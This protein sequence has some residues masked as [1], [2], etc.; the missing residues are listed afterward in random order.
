MNQKTCCLIFILGLVL[1]ACSKSEGPSSSS[2]LAPDDVAGREFRL[3]SNPPRWSV[4]MIPGEEPTESALQVNSSSYMI[5]SPAVYY[6]KTGANTASLSCNFG[7]HTVIGGNILNSYHE[8]EL[9]LVFTTPNQGHYTGIYRNQPEG[10][11]V[12]ETSGYFAFDTEEDPD[13]DPDDD[14][15]ETDYSRL[16]GSWS[17]TANGITK[18]LTMRADKSYLIV[19]SGKGMYGTESGKYAVDQKNA[20]IYLKADGNGTATRYKIILLDPDELE[21]KQYDANTGAYLHSEIFSPSAT[22]GTENGPGQGGGDD[23][24]DDNDNPATS[25]ALLVHL[26]SVQSDRV[27]F[28]IRYKNPGAYHGND[29]YLQAGLC[30]GMTQHPTITDNTTRLERIIPE[31]DSYSVVGNLKQGTVYYMRP[32]SIDKGTV[33]YYQES[34]VETVGNSIVA[35]ISP[36]EGNTV[37]VEYAINAEGTFKVTLGSYNPVRGNTIMVKDFGY[38]KKGASESLKISYPY[39]WEDNRYLFLSIHDIA[40][41]T[42]YQS[43]YQFRP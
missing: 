9:Q 36:Y 20:L 10:G 31:D 39:E 42:V 30:Y 8:Y 43:N 4:R 16:T 24:E 2:G 27:L 1:A 14:E 5:T 21:W 35:R 3:Y 13:F 22:D 28:Q 17:Y 18:Y 40:T 23:G 38:K 33:T 26:S 11:K 37:H 41:E 6:Q 32:Y 34:R 29:K 7:A 15:T 19:V 25:E 12:E